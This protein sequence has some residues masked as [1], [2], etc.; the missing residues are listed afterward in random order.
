[1][2]PY[3]ALTEPRSSDPES[4]F[5][6]LAIACFES[7]AIGVTA[8]KRFNFIQLKSPAFSFFDDFVF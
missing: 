2:S 3:P 6:N 5:A 4:I 8:V 7:P 1:M